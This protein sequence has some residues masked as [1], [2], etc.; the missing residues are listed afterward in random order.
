MTILI[1]GAKG[2]LGRDLVPILSTEYQVLGLDIEELDIQDE[3][4]VNE[5]LQKIRPNLVINAACLYR[6]RSKRT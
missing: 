1:L 6:R 5:E 4:A 3:K 2:M